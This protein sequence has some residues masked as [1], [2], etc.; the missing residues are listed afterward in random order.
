[1]YHLFKVSVK[2]RFGV[3]PYTIEALTCGCAVLYGQVEAWVPCKCGQGCSSS[4]PCLQVIVEYWSDAANSTTR[5]MIYDNEEVSH[6]SLGCTVQACSEP[7]YNKKVIDEYQLKWGQPGQEYICW[8]EPQGERVLRVRVRS[9]N[10]V[11]HSMLW[12]SLGFTLAL[13]CLVVFF[14]VSRRYQ[15]KNDPVQM[16]MRDS[17]TVTTPPDNENPAFHHQSQ[18]TDSV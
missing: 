15:L 18:S 6:Q 10:H 7:S 4:F 3:K 14:F 11:I 17:P 9:K 1:M 16:Q 8:H 12:P 13:V 2:Q 5:A